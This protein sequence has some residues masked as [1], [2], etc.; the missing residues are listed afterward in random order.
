MN[1]TPAIVSWAVFM[2]VVGAER[3]G[4]GS[5]DVAEVQSVSFA[6]AGSIYPLLAMTA[7]FV[8]LLSALFHIALETMREER[9]KEKRDKS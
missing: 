8:L 3:G 1:F 5:A 2:V 6:Q 7:L 9:D 4:A